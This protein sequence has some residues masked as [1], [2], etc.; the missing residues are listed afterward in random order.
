M[1]AL[2]VAAL[3]LLVA[4]IVAW[5]TRRRV[6]RGA[7]GDGSNPELERALDQ[8]STRLDEVTRRVDGLHGRLPMVEAQGR[9]SIQHVGVVRFNPFEDTGGNQSF[10]L[11]LL[12]SKRDG[13]VI[14]SLHS[15]QATR[16]YLKAIAGGKC[17]TALSDEEAEALRRAEAG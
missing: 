6:R 9:R 10:A 7:A 17:E 1:A 8:A 11:A 15:R 4:L 2:V 16:L 5:R 12:D 14:S 3:A 13:I